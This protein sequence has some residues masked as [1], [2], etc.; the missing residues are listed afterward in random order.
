MPA[1]GIG[2]EAAAAIDPHVQAK[3][4]MKCVL[5]VDDEP[6]I[7]LAL[8]MLVEMRGWQALVARSGGEGLSLVDRADAVVT[9]LWMPDMDGFELLAAIRRRD[10]NLPVIVLTAHGSERL[11]DR[12]KRAGA[13]D[14]VTKPFDID[15]MG[16]AI[17]R[18]LEGAPGR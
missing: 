12:A 7:L 4:D 3:S 1:P 14:F 17:E 10:E 11:A 9:D 16:F 15:E 6:V 5:L 8:K 2:A 18:V 13:C